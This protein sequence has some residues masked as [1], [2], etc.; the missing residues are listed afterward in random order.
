MNN[1]KYWFMGAII[2]FALVLGLYIGGQLTDDPYRETYPLMDQSGDQAI[3]PYIDTE[4]KMPQVLGP[5]ILAELAPIYI[6]NQVLLDDW[7]NLLKANEEIYSSMFRVLDYMDAYAQDRTW[8]NLLKARA[9]CSAALVEMRQMELP[10]SQLSQSQIEE[11]ADAGLEINAF[12]REFEELENWRKSMCDTAMLL[13]YTLEDDVFMKASVEIAIP[14][15]VEFYREYFTLEYRYLG[16]YSN[17]LVLQFHSEPEWWNWI[18]LLPHMQACAGAWHDDLDEVL[19]AADETLDQMQALQTEMGSFLGI[20]E[21][22][23]QIVSEAVDTGDLETLRREVNRF[24]DAPGYFP[25]PEWLPDVVHLYLVTDPETQEKRLVR[26]GE[27]LAT[28]PSVCYISCGEIAQA[29]VE[30]YVQRLEQW[31]IQT[32]GAWNEAGDAYQVLAVSGASS[33]MVE[34]TAE[35]T[36]IYLTDPVGCLIPE[37]YLNAIM[38]E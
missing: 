34:W 26:A 19:N 28:V 8:D 33:M 22:T 23:L 12:L 7:Y 13:N 15:M 3:K 36:L 6:G 1:R 37:L 32:Y 17:Y 2:G 31:G 18:R 29:Q 38:I 27:E 14:D 5:N 16:Q 20:S 9:S 24:D 21:Y 4:P 25:T 11:Y 10:Q 35:D 30:S